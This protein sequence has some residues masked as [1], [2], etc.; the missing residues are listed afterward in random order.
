MNDD[1]MDPESV[2]LLAMERAFRGPE[3]K[4]AQTAD[5][6]PHMKRVL[7]CVRE[8]D[9]ML[10][11]LHAAY[12]RTTRALS[13]EQEWR[14]ALYEQLMQIIV[15]SEQHPDC[16]VWR[17]IEQEVPGARVAARWPSGVPL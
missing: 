16:P 15:F 5:W 17:V 1:Q 13:R 11:S 12:G 6:K 2:L 9:P 14:R 3:Y 7:Q 4:D 10:E 8:N